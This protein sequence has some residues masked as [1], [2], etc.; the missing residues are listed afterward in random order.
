MPIK[1]QAP[2][3]QPRF[4][5]RPFTIILTDREAG[6]GQ[7]VALKARLPGS[8]WLAS[9]LH[10]AGSCCGSGQKDP[11]PPAALRQSHP[12]RG[13]VAAI[14]GK[15]GRQRPHLGRAAVSPR[16]ARRGRSRNR[17]LRHAG[18]PRPEHQ[19]FRSS[20]RCQQA[21]R[22]LDRRRLARY[23]PRQAAHVFVFATALADTLPCKTSS[24]ASQ[25]PQGRLTR[26]ELAAL[27]SR[28]PL[29]CRPIGN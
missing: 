12:P 10:R 13:L 15:P 17:A 11:L 24:S 16:P 29:L 23:S 7:P 9:S 2:D 1:P 21:S 20:G 18:A 8:P 3:T 6:V 4:R 19:G 14:A 22:R 26:W 5:L 28:K 25:Q 27:P